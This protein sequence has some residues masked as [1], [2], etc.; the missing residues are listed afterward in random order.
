[1][2]NPIVTLKALLDT[3]APTAQIEK[4]L[5]DCWHLLSVQQGS[6]IQAY[7]LR[8]RINRVDWA[9]PILT[10]TIDRHDAMVAGGS[11]YA[12]IQ[13]WTVRLDAMSAS[14]RTVGRRQLLPKNPPLRVEPIAEEIAASIMRH[15]E[16][17]HL[18]WTKDGGGVKLRMGHLL[19]GV[20]TPK[21]T[22]EG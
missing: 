22:Y 3:E 13:E 19:G 10:F 8:R 20:G 17:P 7:K 5:A 1:M 18:T 4:S 21:Q 11:I 12:E 9:D 16:H 2:S 15:E 14:Y 6:G